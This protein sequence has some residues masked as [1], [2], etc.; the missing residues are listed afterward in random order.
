MKRMKIE[1]EFQAAGIIYLFEERCGVCALCPLYNKRF[2][3]GIIYHEA[4]NY[5]SNIKKSEV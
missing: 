2:G 3:C 5:I 1:N 4:V